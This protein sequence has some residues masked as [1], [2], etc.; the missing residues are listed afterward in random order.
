MNCAYARTEPESSSSKYM[1]VMSFRCH[2]ERKIASFG[3]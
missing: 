3:W 2:F 1:Y